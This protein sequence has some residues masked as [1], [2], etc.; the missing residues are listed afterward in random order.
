MR[1]FLTVVLVVGAIWLGLR[2]YN[3]AKTEVRE[4]EKKETVDAWNKPAPGK[5]PGMPASLE[6]GLET[7]KQD[8]ATGLADWLARN[9]A[10]VRDPRLA[11]IEL[12][13]VVLVGGSDRAEAKR[14]LEAIGRR[15]R[16]DSPVHA[17]YEQLK[18]AYE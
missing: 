14:A 13:Y 12:D 10:Q 3:F 4:A 15:I 1:Q 6:S 11:E 2:F 16:S 9:R 8:G 5:L 17:R 18:K 7:A